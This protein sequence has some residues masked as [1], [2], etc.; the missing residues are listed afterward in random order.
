MVQSWYQG[1]ISI[2]DWTDAEN[3][4]EIAFFDRGPVDSTRFQMGG[5]WSVYWYNGVIVSSEIARGLDIFELKP[6]PYLTKNEIAA[7]RTVELERLN[8]QGQPKFDWPPS[9]A[10]AKAYLDQLERNQ[11]LAEETIAS[12]RQQIA[13]AENASGSERS[14]ILSDLSNEVESQADDSANAEKVNKLAKTLQKLA[15]K[16]M[17]AKQ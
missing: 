17:A 16:N 15:S 14:E 4:V 11:A 5:S 3:P 9:F 13:K 2:F 12:T 8:A 10:L 6:S 1:G 7:A